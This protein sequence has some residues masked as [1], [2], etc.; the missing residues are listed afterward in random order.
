MSRQFEHD[1]DGQIAYN[2]KLSD[3]A[4]AVAAERERCAKVCDDIAHENRVTRKGE[5]ASLC[6]NRIR[7]SR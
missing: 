3:I 5:G 2:D 6:A 4:K 1:W 7:G